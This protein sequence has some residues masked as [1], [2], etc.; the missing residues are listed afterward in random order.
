MASSKSLNAIE[1]T[2]EVFVR[3]FSRPITKSQVIS[4]SL[5]QPVQ[6]CKTLF[7]TSVAYLT[8]GR[9]TRGGAILQ[10]NSPTIERS[11]DELAGLL[12][13]LAS[14][15]DDTIKTKGFSILID[16]Q[17]CP[18]HAAKFTVK[19]LQQLFNETI[20][21]V[22]LLKPNNFW[23]RRRSGMSFRSKSKY[24]FP[25]ELLNSIREL[26][27]YFPDSS[28][29]LPQHGGNLVYDH[30]EFTQT[31]LHFLQL[32]QS[33][34][35]TLQ[36]YTNIYNIVQQEHLAANMTGARK[37]LAEVEEC[38]KLLEQSTPRELEA[39]A[40]PLIHELR[41][42]RSGDKKGGGN[43]IHPDLLTTASRLEDLVVRLL[44]QQSHLY[45]HANKRK[46]VL[47]DCYSH[48]NFENEMQQVVS[49][50]HGEAHAFILGCN[51]IG[52]SCKS[53]SLLLEDQLNFEAKVKNWRQNMTD[54]V[55]LGNRLIKEGHYASIA[56]NEKMQQM[57]VHWRSFQDVVS[58]RTGILKLA[59]Y[60]GQKSEQ[61]F[62]RCE[63]WLNG[64]ESDSIPLD[65]KTAQEA[66]R[67]H[68]DIKNI[69]ENQYEQVD[70]DGN[71][72]IEMMRKPKELISSPSLPNYINDIKRMREILYNLRD[73][74][75]HL[76]DLWK[77]R[78]REL[79]H[80]LQ[81]RIFQNECDRIIAW[82]NAKGYSYL[83]KNIDIGN[84]YHETSQL[85]IMHQDFDCEA[86]NQLSDIANLSRKSQDLISF[87]L[88]REIGV[89]PNEIRRCI[90]S[91]ETRIQALKESIIERESILQNTQI[92]HESVDR[93]L[94]LYQA[95]VRSRAD[96][97]FPDSAEETENLIKKV[98]Q[99]H[100][101]NIEDFNSICHT[102]TKITQSIESASYRI[103]EGSSQKLTPDFHGIMSPLN[104][105]VERVHNELKAVEDYFENRLQTLD[106]CL[107]L[108]IFE[109]DA[110]THHT[111]LGTW[112]RELSAQDRFPSTLPDAK[113]VVQKYQKRVNFL[114]QALEIICE[115]ANGL[116]K[117]VQTR[118]L[119]L[120]SSPGQVEA[121]E[122][123]S[124]LMNGLEL[125]QD[126]V[127]KTANDKIKQYQEYIVLLEYEIQY[128]DL[129]DHIAMIDRTVPV[130][131]G[132]SREKSKS[133]LKQI[134]QVDSE[135]QKLS[136]EVKQ[137]KLRADQLSQDKHPSGENI[138]YFAEDLGNNWNKVNASLDKRRH[139]VKVT[140]NFHELSNDLVRKFDEMSRDFNSI[141]FS[142]VS[143]DD[144]HLLKHNQETWKE[145][146]EG[147]AKLNKDGSTLL[148]SLENE[149]KAMKFKP[150]RDYIKKSTQEEQDA[151]SVLQQ[152]KQRLNY[153]LEMVNLK[154]NQAETEVW[155]QFEQKLIVINQIA[156]FQFAA[157]DLMKW[158]S[159]DGLARVKIDENLK[160]TVKECDAQLKRF[161]EDYSKMRRET[162]NRV[163]RCQDTGVKVQ[164]H[165]ADQYN[166]M[167]RI[168][169]I[170]NKLKNKWDSF[171]DKCESRE[172]LLEKALLFQLNLSKI[173]DWRSDTS[174]FFN[175]VEEELNAS[176]TSVQV[177]NII[178]NLKECMQNSE[179]MVEEL[180]Q[181]IKFLSSELGGEQI[182][183]QKHMVSFN[184]KMTKEELERHLVS[185]E[186]R[187]YLLGQIEREKNTEL[188]L[189]KSRD[190]AIDELVKTEKLYI[191]DLQIMIDKYADPFPV[192]GTPES[193]IHLK[194]E[195]FSNLTEIHRFHKSTLFPALLEAD[196]SFNEMAD[197]FVRFK[198]RI[199]ELYTVF[200]R[201]RRESDR[202]LVANTDFFEQWQ[203][204]VEEPLPL[205]HQLIKPIQR[206][207]KYKLLLDKMYKGTQDL[208]EPRLSLKNACK[209]IQH[210]LNITNH[211]MD[212][213]HLDN[214]E[215][216]VQDLGKLV[217]KGVLYLSGKS[218]KLNS[219]K[220]R[221]VFLFTLALVLTKQQEDPS[222]EGSSSLKYICKEVV[223]TEDLKP[224]VQNHETEALKFFLTLKDDKPYFFRTDT[225][226]SKEEWMRHLLT[227]FD[228]YSSYITNKRPYFKAK[229]GFA[230][231]M[232]RSTSNNADS[233][234]TSTPKGF[235]VHPTSTHTLSGSGLSASLSPMPNGE[236]SIPPPPTLHP[237]KPELD[238]ASI[239]EIENT[240][241]AVTHSKCIAD[242]EP[243]ASNPRGLSLHS[244]DDVEIQKKSSRWCWVK[245]NRGVKSVSGWVPSTHLSFPNEVNSELEFSRDTRKS[246]DSSFELV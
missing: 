142:E 83:I 181:Q 92:F 12:N 242:Y 166:M 77:R 182:E 14:I 210:I 241:S 36:Q 13:F 204:K 163:L 124:N 60:F 9:D 184:Y 123:V 25:V 116:T 235:T 3:S 150:N 21:T 85:L 172:K 73:D 137:I 205:V 26:Q 57:A 31:Y 178:S 87:N 49:W 42:K 160:Y 81:A 141:T 4:D 164:V 214:F 7:L 147:V 19:V 17:S 30:S 114:R 212:L 183:K 130:E 132:Q 129:L 169:V 244:G 35:S 207:T 51:K 118:Q 168:Q 97:G 213:L 165:V 78:L 216:S 2:G 202:I 107:N 8:G 221:H 208:S 153:I 34:Q 180:L 22:Y 53:T 222:K 143:P 79:T 109:C 100:T 161:R 66:C 61:F 134:E 246:L 70:K 45:E 6:D 159:V 84:S 196:D 11:P 54:T 40:L 72:M 67:L 227:V 195:I 33:C 152:L 99:L 58:E 5:A 219:D 136:Q 111:R 188:Q 16:C 209:A 59:L 211:Q 223:F 125:R 122:H 149:A 110:N 177:D 71:T 187:K 86:K 237:A 127:L 89:T 18:T 140:C 158:C 155:T 174:S 190:M 245:L 74:K 112:H 198:H 206:I 185:A 224:F 162:G 41:L 135:L 189:R 236:S 215:G 32:I 48:R 27:H 117:Q 63:K 156:N 69:Y 171:Q 176:N 23:E 201:E 230:K 105:Q 55:T 133:I 232:N 90:V 243:D 47:Q 50:I 95:Q 56:V 82:I 233:P 194:R 218:S 186:N 238:L 200:C 39:T 229:S 179:R 228:T 94:V 104:A 139:L 234:H 37:M 193:I 145:I 44:T 68:E 93:V 28:Q 88:P 203:Q 167:H 146:K 128:K 106:V 173:R 148:Q 115:N 20:T 43:R 102:C 197:A 80:T 38:E 217:H 15:P 103:I 29:L 98:K 199:E 239:S 10:I 64:C 231:I 157:D 1:D 62:T 154:L 240:E 119:L 226:E 225:S 192:E 121:V 76:D 120:F 126:E 46:C 96:E 65:I 170:L 52:E 175:E 101:R 191:Q 108:R 24:N 220:P 75:L 131:I 138:Q 151:L 144:R 113:A 91:L